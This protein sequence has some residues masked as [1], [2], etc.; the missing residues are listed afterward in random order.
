MNFGYY[1][2]QPVFLRELVLHFWGKKVLPNTAISPP[3]PFGKELLEEAV[4][5]S[6]DVV[7]VS[8]K[9]ISGC[10]WYLVIKVQGIVVATAKP[11][12]EKA[13]HTFKTTTEGKITVKSM[14]KPNKA[15]PEM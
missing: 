8:R 15:K 9:N 4:V 3:T 7:W 12:P 14:E 5:I 1:K 2:K 6:V 10:S 11:N 13:A